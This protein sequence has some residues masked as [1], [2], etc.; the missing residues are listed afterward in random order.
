M[1]PQWYPMGSAGPA[2]HCPL[3]NSNRILSGK[4]LAEPF[5]PEHLHGGIPLRRQHDPSPAMLAASP[6]EAGPALSHS[7]T[8]YQRQ[9][10]SLPAQALTCLQLAE[11]VVREELAKTLPDIAKVSILL[12]AI[13]SPLTVKDTKAQQWPKDLE[14]CLL[15]SSSSVHD[16]KGLMLLHTMTLN[17]ISSCRQTLQRLCTCWMVS[18]LKPACIFSEYL[19]VIHGCAPE[20]L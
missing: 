8:P 13:E 2:T 5:A 6:E 1:H 10:I 12:G 20:A 3:Q 4:A 11:K 7:H 15:D 18:C 14:V 19:L 9:A 16:K 17:E